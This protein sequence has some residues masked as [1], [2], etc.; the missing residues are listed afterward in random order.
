MPVIEMIVS[1]VGETEITVTGAK[2]ATCRELTADLESTLG[3]QI[4]T[5]DTAE[6]FEKAE[7]I[8]VDQQR[9]G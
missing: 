3:P 4:A 6:A 2:G 7:E 8:K 1:P 5:R 9:D